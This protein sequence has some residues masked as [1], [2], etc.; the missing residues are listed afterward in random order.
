[1]DAFDDA[2]QRLHRDLDNLRQVRPQR[3]R[4]GEGD[5]DEGD[6]TPGPPPPNPNLRFAGMEVTQGI[7]FF[8]FLTPESTLAGPVSS[9]PLVPNKPTV[10]RVYVD[11]TA[12]ASRGASSAGSSRKASPSGSPEAG[13]AARTPPV[14]HLSSPILRGNAA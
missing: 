6:E 7:Q 11:R 1:M 12:R 5:D 13:Q 2:I 9:I 14:N 10:I 8:N 3:I 4:D